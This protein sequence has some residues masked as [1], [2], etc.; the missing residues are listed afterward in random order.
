[1]GRSPSDAAWSKRNGIYPLY[2][3]H[4]LCLKIVKFSSSLVHPSALIRHSGSPRQ[5]P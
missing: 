2:T 3:L 1:M 4:N 5:S